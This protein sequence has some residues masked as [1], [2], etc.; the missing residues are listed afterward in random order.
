MKE[1]AESDFVK[2]VLESSVPVLVDIFADWCGPCKMLAPTLD[3]VSKAYDGRATVVKLDSEKA[4]KVVGDYKVS[5][6]PTLLYFKGG[7]LE[8]RASGLQTE[9][10]IKE[11]LDSLL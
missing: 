10:A 11:T 2:E 4:G 7:K 3:K 6:L 9:K 1:I 5:S 8:S